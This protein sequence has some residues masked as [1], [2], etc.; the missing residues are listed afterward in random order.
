MSVKVNERIERKFGIGKEKTYSR[1]KAAVMG[2]DSGKRKMMASSAQDFEGLLYRLLG[3]GKQGDADMQFFK[4]KLIKTFARGNNALSAQRMAMINDFKAM[5]KELIKAGIPKDLTKKVPGEPYTIEQALR[6]Y[7]WK[8]QGME[9]PDL[10]AAD[11]KSLTDY[12]EKSPALKRFSQQLIDLNRGDGYMAPKKSWLAGTITTDL[13]ENLNKVS[14]AK[15]LQEWQT[16]SDMIFS[17]ENLNKMEAALGSNWRS[18]M[19]NMLKRMKTGR[20]R[21][22]MLSGKMGEMEGKALD[23]VTS[24]VGAIM[25]LNTR[26]AVLTA[27]STIYYT[28]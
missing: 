8:K 17:P 4:D 28:N 19:E 11:L 25:C 6:V 24:S 1:S 20:N 13:Y 2:K 12:V 27:L 26:S 7:T 14:R 22:L 18:A 21:N 23:W 9:V 5:K 3:K 15:H 10:S 16:N